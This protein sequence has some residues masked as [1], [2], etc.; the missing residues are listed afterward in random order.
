[1][2]TTK[3]WITNNTDI[4]DLELDMPEQDGNLHKRKE[5]ARKPIIKGWKK[6][7]KKES[8]RKSKETEGII[9]A[10]LKRLGMHSYHRTKWEC[11]PPLNLANN[12]MAHQGEKCS[13]KW[14]FS[15]GLGFEGVIKGN[16]W[17]EIV[18]G[19]V[20]YGVIQIGEMH[21]GLFL[22]YL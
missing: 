21:L 12:A 8:I 2:I 5:S 17:G 16:E 11:T 14:V 6:Y 19:R 3:A 15:T 7:K 10:T 22:E 20:V 1:M 4:K 9:Q 13:P 18:Q